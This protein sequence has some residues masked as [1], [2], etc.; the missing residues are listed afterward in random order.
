[1]KCVIGSKR[2]GSCQSYD[3]SACTLLPQDIASVGKGWSIGCGRTF[4]DYCSEGLII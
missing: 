4:G 2:N 3:D 1:M